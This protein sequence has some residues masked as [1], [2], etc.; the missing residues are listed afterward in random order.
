MDYKEGGKRGFLWRKKGGG[1]GSSWKQRFYVCEDGVL[2][3]FKDSTMLNKESEVELR[4]VSKVEPK[5]GLAPKKTQT[6]G[7][8][9]FSTS[10]GVEYVLCAEGAEER[11]EWAEM[12]S[13]HMLIGRRNANNAA[14]AAPATTVTTSSVAVVTKNNVSALPLSRSGSQAVPP[15]ALT[16]S[17]TTNPVASP[18]PQLKKATSTVSASAAAGK[19][20]DAELLLQQ[21]RNANAALRRENEQLKHDA[22]Q[23]KATEA[24]LRKELDL[25]KKLYKGER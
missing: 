11:E 23:A 8:F 5:S 18:P 22:A 21:E 16:K 3:A 19:S 24:S 6:E 9:S 15:S 20:K 4:L 14:N 12:I 13:L 2:R 10:E 1:L 17:G 25:V 7:G